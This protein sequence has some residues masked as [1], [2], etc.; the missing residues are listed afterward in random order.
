MAQAGQK[1]KIRGPC[2]LIPH[3]LARQPN[4]GPNRTEPNGFMDSRKGSGRA[5]VGA[6]SDASPIKIKPTAKW[7]SG[8][9]V[10]R[11]RTDLI[12]KGQDAGAPAVLAPAPAP[13]LDVSPT[14]H[15]LLP[16]CYASQLARPLGHLPRRP[17]RQR[18]AS[19][20]GRSGRTTSPNEPPRC[21]R[22]PTGS[23]PPNYRRR[24]NQAR[25]GSC[26]SVSCPDGS[27]GLFKLD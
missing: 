19:I 10:D 21:W 27:G 3:R 2:K 6:G 18:Q 23:R 5:Q 1:T 22:A 12:R 26:A 15:N 11:R 16:P 7:T 13:V 20:I 9:P 24:W 25:D 17:K 8:Q 4:S 14:R